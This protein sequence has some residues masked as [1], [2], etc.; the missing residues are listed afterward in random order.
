M[1]LNQ[2]TGAGYKMAA[3]MVINETLYIKTDS[4]RLTEAVQKSVLEVLEDLMDEITAE[5][6]VDTGHLQKHHFAESK[7]T[8]N[9]IQAK[10]KV[11]EAEYWKDVQYGNRYRGAD[12]YLTRALANAPPIP[13]TNY[14][15]R[16]YLKYLK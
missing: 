12:P 15:L 6:P 10:I 5:V 11:G 2:G 4:R 16:Q 1:L 8:N 7:M 13:K 9:G 3:S 14:Y